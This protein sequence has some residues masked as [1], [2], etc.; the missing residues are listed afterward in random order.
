MSIW[1]DVNGWPFPPTLLLGCLLLEVLYFRGWSIITGGIEAKQAQRRLRA[2]GQADA[3]SMAQWQ[4][5]LWRGISFSG[6]LLALLLI[7]SAPVDF[8]AGRLL[9]VHMVQHIF[10]LGVVPP[11]LVAGA[12]LLPLWL[13]LPRRAHRLV[14]KG[15]SLPVRRAAYR[16]GSWL[17]HQP[18]LASLLFVAG[19]WLW[20]WPNLYD[21]ALTNDLI[22][23]W[24]EH[25]TFLAVSIFF[26][27]QIISAP[28]A[29]TSPGHLSRLSC[30]GIAI[31][32]NV[33]LAA[34][35]GF[36][37][38]PAYAPYAHLAPGVG[39]LTALQDQHLGAGIM[40]TFGDLPF[41]LAFSVLTHQWLTLQLG[42]DGEVEL[43]E[44]Q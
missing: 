26:W 44:R 35:L 12:P 20:H 13:G 22:H 34:V 2:G 38:Q 24:L 40:W 21:L 7:S 9:W 10:L 30:L 5:W 27:A 4:A 28:H 19:I 42:E 11:L 18:V 31:V 39:A 6:S 29:H 33:M 1:V 16:V 41:G 32:Q 17:L 3:T 37:Q 14:K 15:I 43:K 25:T 23:D 36:A 8:F